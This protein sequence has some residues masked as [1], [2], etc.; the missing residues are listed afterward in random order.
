VCQ[1]LSTRHIT[2]ALGTTR[3]VSGKAALPFRRALEQYMD[4]T[5]EVVGGCFW[6]LVKQ[7][8]IFS[9]RWK[10]LKTGAVLVDAPGVH[11]DN[12]AR[13]AV[14]KAH[15][16]D[17][18]AVWIVSNIVRAVNDKTGAE[19]VLDPSTSALPS[20]C[21][22]AADWPAAHPEVARSRLASA[23]KDML[24]ENFRRQLL[25]D[26][27]FGSLAFIATHSDVLRRAEAIRSLKLPDDATLRECAL[28][29]NR[30]TEQR[31]R[32]DFAAGLRE[33]AAQAGDRSAGGEAARADK[34]P[35]FTVSSIDFQKLSGL[36]PAD[37]PPSVWDD[38]EQTHIP[39]LVRH[40]QSSALARRK[41]LSLRRCEAMVAFGDSI[42]TTLEQIKAG[43]GA[44][45]T[46]AQL[47]PAD[48][49]SSVEFLTKLLA[50]FEGL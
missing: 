14:V 3:T 8:R 29:R 34:L 1:L 13:D 12:S 2:S 46:G 36:R 31:L 19:L 9:S 23:A 7:V 26:G 15:L 10:V 49:K 22:L 48:R 25:M 28:A 21:L 18:D 41:V 45:L 33:L 11:D 24:S 50:I 6:P 39:A 4:S 27:H 47:D 32:S 37:G 16:K 17:A 42:T 5:N 38:V 30:Y 20:H 43:N 35:V 40:V 44:H